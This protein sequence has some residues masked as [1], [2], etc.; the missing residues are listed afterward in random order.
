MQ[1]V[2]AGRFVFFPHRSAEKA[3]P[4]IRHFA[5]FAALPNVIVAVRIV[6]AAAALFK[7]FVFVGRMIYNQVHDDLYVAFFRFGN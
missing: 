6:D 3:C 1:V 2:L 4:V 5:V 7:P